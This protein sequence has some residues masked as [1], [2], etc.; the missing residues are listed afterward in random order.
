[1]LP[2][3]LTAVLFLVCAVP[4]TAQ[5]EPGYEIR[6][7]DR[8]TTRLFTAAGSEVGVVDGERIVDVN[9]NVFLPYVGSVRVAGYDE[10][11]LRDLLVD[12]YRQFYDDPVVDIRVE[13]RV[14]VTGAVGQAGRYYLDP[15][16]T[17]MDAMAAAGGVGS[18]FAVSG[19]QVPADP[20]AVRL[21]RDGELII[22]NLRPDEVDR[23]V[24]LMRI[25]SGDW[26]HVPSRAR[27]RVRDEITFWGS[28]ISFVASAIGLV[29]LIGR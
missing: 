24:L 20:T 16:A 4:A 13:L 12:A 29:I 17:I 7:G 6:P 1:M 3:F 28:V 19:T 14:N 23:S 26:F 22:L 2:R 15:T 9:G 21:V 8:L 10:T 5:E 25:Q 11:R 18:E 27:S